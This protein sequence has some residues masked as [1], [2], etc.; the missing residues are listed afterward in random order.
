MS[1]PRSS[2]SGGGRVAS[3]VGRCLASDRRILRSPPPP[4]SGSREA[5][6]P[7]V[8]PH[9]PHPPGNHP[10]WRRSHH[11]SSASSRKRNVGSYELRTTSSDFPPP[12]PPHQGEVAPARATEGVKHQPRTNRV[13]LTSAER[14]K[15]RQCSTSPPRAEPLRRSSPK[16]DD[17][18]SEP[19]IEEG[20]LDLP[21]APPPADIDTVPPPTTSPSPNSRRRGRSS[22]P[23]S[24][25]ISEHGVMP[26]YGSRSRSRSAVVSPCSPCRT[27]TLPPRATQ[28]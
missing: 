10:R 16:P 24:G 1:R 28:R 9:P 2:T 6:R 27:T 11:V 14:L 21:D 22:S 23:G 25:R 12:R 15:K 5:S 8:G 19:P 3:V 26:S 17:T 20:K 4:P 13:P 18:P 7:R